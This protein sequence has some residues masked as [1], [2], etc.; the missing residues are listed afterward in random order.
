MNYYDRNTRIPVWNFTDQ[1]LPIKD[2][3][4]KSLQF[5]ENWGD[6]GIIWVLYQDQHNLFI[7]SEYYLKNHVDKNNK[8]LFDTMP[9]MFSTEAKLSARLYFNFNTNDTGITSKEIKRAVYY[10][11]DGF[12]KIGLRD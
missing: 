7:A 12:V 2:K 5:D 9:R 4:I 3:R 6:E 1:S 10:F 8:S 11:E